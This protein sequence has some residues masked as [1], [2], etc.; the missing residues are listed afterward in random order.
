MN[1]CLAPSRKLS[2]GQIE[3]V[4]MRVLHRLR[5]EPMWQSD[6]P[7]VH[8]GALR[9]ARGLPR[10]VAVPAAAALALVLVGGTLAIRQWSAGRTA[11]AVVETVDGG[12]YRVAD[13]R[14]HALTVNERI[15]FGDTVRSNGG[16]GGTLLLADGS[17]VE[18]R[19]Q[20]ELS[21][22]RAED[23]VRIELARGGIIV[24]AAKQRSGHLYVKTRDV[25]VSVVGT[26]F[27][28]NADDDGSRVAVIE[29]EVRVQQ[30]ATERNLGPGEQVTTNPNLEPVP[31]TSGLDWS[32][33]AETH[34]ALLQQSISSAA[35]QAPVVQSPAANRVAF[36][37]ISIRPSGPAPPVAPGARGGGGGKNSRPA[38]TG[39]VF[40]S[41]GYSYQ[42]DPRRFAVARVT[43]LHL[44]AYTL[45][46]QSLEGWPAWGVWSRPDISCGMLT[47]TGLLSGGPEWIRV[48][49]WDIVATIPEGTFTSAPTLTDPIVRQ[50]LQTLLTERF[51]VGIRRESR[52]LTVY[53]LKV[54]KD[55]PKFNGQ[56]P[57]ATNRDP[58]RG[59]VFMVRGPDG[60]TVRAADMPPPPEGGISMIGPGR[61]F[62]NN[63]SMTNWANHLFGLDG[64][65]V[66]DRTGLTGRY[67]FHYEDP[68]LRLTSPD[69][70]PDLGPFNHAIVKAMGFELEESRA[71][72]DAWII[73]RAEKPTG[74]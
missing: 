28:V 65:P 48:D 46:V 23:G 38:E 16:R 59:P 53:L 68:S 13:G 43:L 34:R 62:A 4:G 39:C 37:E 71:P 15:G 5:A 44:A 72:Y 12:L 8:N 49:M 30:G 20:S 54:G 47:R 11:S 17:R 33:E 74:N 21:V 56:S 60:K 36:E 45:P 55:G 61:F 6:A 27:L 32:R 64:R 31:V 2:R 3:M 69:V 19:T 57:L 42:L 18:M 24:N 7:L 9:P 52:D 25:T 41:M 51:K 35:A 58:N 22:E 1:R 26:V 63:V 70:M 66:L 29:G 67:D 14:T 10:V 73:D 50:M 40:D